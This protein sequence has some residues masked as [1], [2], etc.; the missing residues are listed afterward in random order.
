MLSKPDNLHPIRIDDLLYKDEVY[1]I[2][3][4]AFETHKILGSGFLE[5][6]YQEAFEY[7]LIKRQIPFVSQPCLQI[8][9]KDLTLSKTFKADLVAYE[10]IIIEVKAIEKLS[11]IDDSQIINYLKATQMQLGIILNFGSP[12]LEWRQRV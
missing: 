10:K 2:M 12:K 6:I 3:G 8:K 4:A 9:Y 7:E 1:A 11:S 5:P